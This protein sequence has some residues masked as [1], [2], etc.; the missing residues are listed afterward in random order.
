[1]A[2]DNLVQPL[3]KVQVAL[4]AGSRPGAADLIGSPLALTWIHGVASGGVTPFEYALLG[5][6]P[7]DSVAVEVK[8][9]ALCEYFGHIDDALPRL[10]GVSG[11]LETLCL[12]MEVVAVSAA[13]DREV[14]AATARA[15]SHGGC[16]GSCGCGCS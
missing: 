16:G 4:I 14:V 7:G 9:A 12:Q 5:K 15:L 10:L 11:A 1:M 6:K 8:T 2:S 3:R 13:A